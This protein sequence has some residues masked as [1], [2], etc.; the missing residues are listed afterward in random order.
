MIWETDTNKLLVYDGS[1][2]K[3]VFPVAAPV[4]TIT[5]YAG[6]AAPTG[7]LL[8]DGSAVSRSTYADLFAILSTTYGSGNGSTTFNLPDFRGRVQMGAGT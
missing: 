5:Q 3:D 8:C 7:Y 4:G 1:V 6:A 2:W